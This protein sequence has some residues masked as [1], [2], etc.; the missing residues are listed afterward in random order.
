M[1]EIKTYSK[2]ERQIAVNILLLAFSSDPF[3]RYLM[4]DSSIF[5][6]N[7]AIWFDN[8]A[9]QSISL[10]ALLGTTNYS[11]VALWFPP[12]HIIEFEALKE[13]F[14][15]LPENSQKDIFQYFREFE[16]SR[17]KDAWYLEYLGVDPSKH[18][19]G[20]GS[21]LLN[22]FISL[23]FSANKAKNFSL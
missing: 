20:L 6:K 5:L 3:Q 8:A 9:N 11:G 17:P 7:S 13:T 14:N 19:L 15:E 21:K 12:N 10:K 22:L 18:S 23:L 4:P 1:N 16:E 2:E